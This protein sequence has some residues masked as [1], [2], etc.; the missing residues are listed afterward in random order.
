MPHDIIDNLETKLATEIKRFLNDSQRA[1]FAVGYFFI[2]GMKP[3]ISELA[4]L[5]EIKLLIGSS[6]NRKTIEAV[7]LG[8]KRLD[9]C[10]NLFE[11]KQYLTPVQV[12]DELAENKLSTRAVVEGLAQTDDNENL[13]KQVAR[14][15]ETGKLKVKVYLKEP[16]HAKA[17]IFDFPKER[18]FTGAAIVGSSNLTFAGLN[19]N[20]ELN[21]VVPGNGNHEKLS[22]WFDQLWDNAEDF[23]AELLTELNLSWAI[24]EPTPYELYLKVIYELVKDRI[25]TEDSMVTNKIPKLLLFDYQKDAVVH[26]KKILDKYNGVFIS[27]VVGLGKTFVTS[28][29]LAEYW[30]K[31]GARALIICP[32]K[33]V[34]NWVQVTSTFGIPMQGRIVSSGKLEDLLDDTQLINDTTIV[35]VDESHHFKSHLSQRYQDLAEI[36][37]GKKVILVTA[38]PYNLSA[39]DIYHQLKL[40]H[41][42]EITDIPIDPPNLRKYFIAVDKKERDL[43]E[44]LWHVLIRRTRRDI[45][46]HYPEDM[47]KNNLKFPERKGPFRID[48]SIDQVYPG[49]Y[50]DIVKL[51][52][53]VKYARY[54][55]G[56]YVKPECKKEQELKQLSSISPHIKAIIKSIVLKR[57]ESSYVAFQK[58]IRNFIAI[59]TAFLRAVDK[60]IIPAGPEGEE[61]IE[62]MIDTDDAAVLAQYDDSDNKYQ[63]GNFD[64]AKMMKDLNNDLDVFKQLLELVE[65]IVPKEDAKLSKLLTE[66]DSKQIKGKKAIIFTQ[67]EATQQYLTEQLKSRYSKTEG[68]SSKTFDLSK[69]VKRFAPKANQVNIKE[70]DEIQILVATDVL[71]EGL[72][73]QDCNIIIN[74]DLH[75][76]PVRLI[77]RVGRIDRVT[78][79]HNEIWTYNFFPEKELDR[80]LSFTGKVKNRMQE[81]HDFIGEDAKYLSQDEQLQ[82]NKFFK[83]YENNP[84]VL[85]DDTGEVESTFED[86]AQLMKQLKLEKPA[87]FTKILELPSKIRSCKDWKNSGIVAFCKYGDYYKFYQYDENKNITSLDQSVALKIL[88]CKPEAERKPL[89]QGFNFVV[90]NIEKIFTADIMKRKQDLENKE[91]DPLLRAYRDLLRGCAR[92]AKD[93]VKTKVSELQSLLLS[94]PLSLEQR[95]QMRKLK[96]ETFDSAKILAKLESILK[97]KGVETPLEVKQQPDIEIVCSEGLV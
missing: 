14:F 12:G 18:A 64:T 46:R 2:S 53:T 33:L 27:D 19:S 9:T 82:E 39:D 28:A 3:I 79:E 81:I 70:S 66:L 55:L 76:N 48:Y 56:A 52:K 59:Y 34:N 50:D 10:T 8:Y 71:S 47:K 31:E 26:A 21:V 16:L 17:Y 35:V 20:T 61:L 92:G 87:M 93:E 78:T 1:K 83:I 38:T 90:Q 43:K 57:F 29:L 44:L 84:T 77:Q 73:L 95:K 96:R 65:T 67:Y 72:N 86:Y 37:F 75:W 7:A 15:I 4:Q 49:I 11:S 5:E 63:A 40:F 45:Q 54:N 41:P 89:P 24:N 6:T 88:E 36:L 94:K 30:E 62:S 91:N 80:H 32:P 23:N 97:K 58:S 42:Q 68:V 25:G 85:D 22:T 60:G 51:L 74:Y 13:V 69:I